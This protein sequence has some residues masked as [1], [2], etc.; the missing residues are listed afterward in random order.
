[1]QGTGGALGRRLST[2][3]AL[4]LVS[5]AVLLFSFAFVFYRIV[6]IVGD[7]DAY[8][9]LVAASIVLAT[10][11]SQVLRARTALTIGA[12]LFAIGSWSYISALPVDV[13]ARQSRAINDVLALLTGLSVLRLQMIELW[14]LG[15]AP[16]PI[17]LTWY[18]AMRRRYVA[19]V[20][21]GGLWAL[22]GE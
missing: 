3:R 15:V 13:L 16:T 2:P 8:L 7:P 14:V 6:D 19:T 9:V 17:F 11:L 20:L 10:A 22:D 5:A 12:G 18:L 1:L 4:A 21:A